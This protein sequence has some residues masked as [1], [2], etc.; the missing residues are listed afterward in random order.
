MS[1]SPAIFMES[2]KAFVRPLLEYASPVWSPSLVFKET[3]KIERVQRRAT[4]R[5][6]AIRNFQYAVHP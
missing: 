6:S 5:V 3:E 2:F 1:R 4:K